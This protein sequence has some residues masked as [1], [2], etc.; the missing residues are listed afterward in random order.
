MFAIIINENHHDAGARLVDAEALKD[1]G[2]LSGWERVWAY[3]DTRE[4]A[5]RELAEARAYAWKYLVLG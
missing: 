1:N 5:E 3:A 2:E 4:E